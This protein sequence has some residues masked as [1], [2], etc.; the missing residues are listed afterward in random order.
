MSKRKTVQHRHQPDAHLEIRAEEG[1]P[2]GIAG[3]LRGVA[4]TYEVIDTFGTVFGRGALTRTIRDKVSAR[5]VPLLM[6][7][8]RRTGAHVGVVASMQE[9]GDSVIMVADLFDTPEG[10]AALEY[11]KAVIAAG[12]QTGFS[13]G[14]VPIRSGATVVDGQPVERFSEIELREVSLTPMPAVPGTELLGARTEGPDA[15]VA[16]VEADESATRSDVELL[17]LAAD[18]ALSALPAEARAAVLARFTAPA[19]SPKVESTATLPASDRADCASPTPAA[20]RF[21]SGESVPLDAR[22]RAVRSTFAY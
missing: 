2:E 1:L 17:T 11:A 12:A 10:R 9:L 20:P 5:R 16:V 21:T 19:V 14:F 15:P 3:R 4:L 6:D 7:H 22:L 13:I 18:A 8:D